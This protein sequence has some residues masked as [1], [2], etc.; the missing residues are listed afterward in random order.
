MKRQAV[1]EP[2]IRYTELER[3]GLVEKLHPGDDVLR[4]LQQRGFIYVEGKISAPQFVL[5][6]ALEANGIEY[7]LKSFGFDDGHP[8]PEIEISLPHF[9]DDRVLLPDGTR[10]GREIRMPQ[11][12]YRTFIY[13]TPYS[14]VK[15]RNAFLHTDE[16]GALTQ[17]L[18]TCGFVAYRGSVPLSFLQRLTRNG[19]ELAMRSYHEDGIEYEIQLHGFIDDREQAD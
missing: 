15:K 9:I 5:L 11:P 13:D 4:L 19:F 14:V 16:R 2:I 3:K 6:K 18:T 12:T 10:G 1:K 8:N 17:V 7:Q